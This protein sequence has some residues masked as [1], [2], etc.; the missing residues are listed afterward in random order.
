MPGMCDVYFRG[1]HAQT[2]TISHVNPIR[3]VWSKSP[4]RRVSGSDGAPLWCRSNNSFNAPC[5]LSQSVIKQGTVDPLGCKAQCNHRRPLPSFSVLC[6]TS[7]F[8]SYP[9]VCCWQ[10]IGWRQRSE[11]DVYSRSGDY[12]LRNMRKYYLSLC[13]WTRNEMFSLVLK[14]LALVS[15]ISCARS[16][17]DH[18]R[19]SEETGDHQ[20]SCWAV[21][22]AARHWVVIIPGRNIRNILIVIVNHSCGISP[23]LS[24]NLNSPYN[25]TKNKTSGSGRQSNVTVPS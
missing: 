24:P 14:Q 9:Q 20:D 25:V 15:N 3:P 23:L 4:Q 11:D 5:F 13:F 22:T 19:I 12:Q 2:A 16:D 1:V 21:F 7:H 6:K 17:R 8:K 10:L 18:D